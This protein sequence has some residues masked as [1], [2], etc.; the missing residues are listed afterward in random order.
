MHIP[1]EITPSKDAVVIGLLYDLLLQPYECFVSFPID[2][3]HIDIEYSHQRICLVF[4]PRRLSLRCPRH[5]RCDTD[6]LHITRE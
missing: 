4:W 1:V 3:W 6:L 2:S 5:L